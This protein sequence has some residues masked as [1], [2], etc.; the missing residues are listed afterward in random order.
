MQR[1]VRAYA[2]SIGDRRPIL[3]L[4]LPGPWGRALRDGT[5]LP[6]P[7]AESGVQT[8]DDWLESNS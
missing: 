6:G 1:L 8:F 3:A 7:E 5:L 4:P 2:R